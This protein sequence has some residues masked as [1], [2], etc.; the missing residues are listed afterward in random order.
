MKRKPETH[1]LRKAPRHVL[2]L[3]CGRDIRIP[4]VLVR[5]TGFLRCDF[6]GTLTPYKNG[7]KTFSRICA[8]LGCHAI[9]TVKRLSV[10]SILDE[11]LG[12]EIRTLYYCASHAPK[13]T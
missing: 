13:E 2:C 4:D 3:S 1:I 12:A 6:D 5:N 10:P 11:S 9:A 8:V 7:T